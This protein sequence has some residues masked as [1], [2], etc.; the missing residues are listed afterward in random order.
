LCGLLGLGG[1]PLRPAGGLEYE[2]FG[3]VFDDF[4]LCNIAVEFTGICAYQLIAF[5]NLDMC[6]LA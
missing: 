2:G 1:V 6:Q 4:E 3:F 5:P